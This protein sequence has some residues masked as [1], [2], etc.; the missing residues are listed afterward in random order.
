MFL[1]ICSGKAE[2]DSD[3]AGFIERCADRREVSSEGPIR[4]GWMAYPVAR[5]D[6][7]ASSQRDPLPGERQPLLRTDASRKACLRCAP[8]LRVSPRN[9]GP[10]A[11]AAWRIAGRPTGRERACRG[12]STA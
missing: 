2:A 9:G 10:R 6:C 11:A 12:R 7:G 4:S 1:V 3:L 8:F 5:R